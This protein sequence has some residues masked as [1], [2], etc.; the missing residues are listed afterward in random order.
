M[1]PSR[2]LIIEDDTVLLR[3]YSQVLRIQNYDV[4][5]AETIKQAHNHLVSSSFDLLLCDV[6]I[7]SEKSTDLLNEMQGVIRESGAT[8]ILMSAE[9]RYRS[10][11]DQLGINMFL[12]K[13]VAP[14][15]LVDLVDQFLQ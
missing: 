13:P 3:L 6:Q 2:I 14:T 10:L 5:I 4:A 8:V 12:V 11:G 15:E 9:E 1:S 7:G